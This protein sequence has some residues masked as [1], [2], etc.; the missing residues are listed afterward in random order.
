MFEL[1]ARLNPEYEQVRAHLLSQP[2]VSSLFE[3]YAFLDQEERRRHAM[4]P[5]PVVERSALVSTS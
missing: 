5:A 3:V 1:L 4:L 2:H